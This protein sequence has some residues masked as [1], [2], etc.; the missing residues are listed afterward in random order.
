LTTKRDRVEVRQQRCRY[1]ILAANRVQRLM[2]VRGLSRLSPLRIQQL[3]APA[4]RRY[5]PSAVAGRS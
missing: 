4:E 3:V 5:A 1:E 2:T